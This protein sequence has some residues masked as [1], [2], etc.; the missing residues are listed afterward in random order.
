M[1]NGI[2]TSLLIKLTIDFWYLSLIALLIKLVLLRYT[3]TNKIG[4]VFMIWLTGSVTFFT[5]ACICGIVFGSAGFY[6]IPFIMYIFAVG[7]E[8]TFASIAF[9]IEAKRLMP[10]VIIGDGIFFFLLF[11]QWS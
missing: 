8:L 5:I 4:K 2:I 7:A 11:I 10:A 9:R 1:P 3:A 6:Y